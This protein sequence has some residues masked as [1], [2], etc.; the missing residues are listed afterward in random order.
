M[1]LKS[2]R[3]N[4]FKSFA[5]EVELLFEEGITVIVG[6]N[7]CGKSNISDAIRWVLGEQSARSLR[8]ARMEEVIF[9]GGST[10]SP[11]KLAY[12]AL[13]LSNEDGFLPIDSPE[14]E[15]ARQ[16][17]R[18]GESRYFINGSQCLLRD[19]QNLFLDTGIGTNAYYLMEQN[20]IDFILNSKPLERRYLFDE[21]AGIN[22]YKRR[23]AEALRK[24][25]ETE[26]NLARINDV[27][28][29]LERE[30]ESLREQAERARIYL[31]LMERLKKADI[32]RSRRKYRLLTEELEGIEEKLEEVRAKLSEREEELARLEAELGESSSR[33]EEIDAEIEEIQGRIR[34]VESELDRTRSNIEIYADRRKTLLASAA[35]MRKEIEAASKRR[36]ELEEEIRRRIDERR[37]VEVN[38]ELERNRLR[39]H[40]SFIAEMEKRIRD[41]KEEIEVIR[42]RTIQV[43]EERSRVQNELSSL[44]SKAELSRKRLARLSEEKGTLEGELD[45]LRSSLEESRRR[46]KLVEAEIVGLNAELRSVESELKSLQEELRR[47]EAE[48]SGTQNSLGLALS[49]L[50]SLKER[51]SSYE[52][53]IT[54]VRAV[55]KAKELKPEEFKGICG[56]VGELI[57]TEP[58]YELAI[59]VALG[60]G[61]HNVVTE[62]AEDAQKAIEL[63]KSARAGRVTF[64][65][66]DLLRARRFEGSREMLLQPGVIGIASELVRFDPKYSVVIEYL[67]GN[68]LVVESLEVAVNLLRRFGSPVRFVTLEGEMVSPSGAITGGYGKVKSS[69]LLSRAREI[70]ELEERA[71][72]LSMKLREKDEER[73]AVSA[74]ISALQKRRGELLLSSQEGRV[75]L[76]ELSKEIQSLEE[77]ERRLLGQMEVL[78]SEGEVIEREL[79]EMEGEAEKL[80]ARL[81]EL[82]G[83]ETTLGR[84]LRRLMEQVEIEEGK[85]N[86]VEKRCSEERVKLAKMEEQLRGIQ[87]AIDAMEEERRRIGE[88]IEEMR[89]QAESQEE[90]KAELSRRIEEEKG[91][92]MELEKHLAELR[93]KLASLQGERE[94]VGRRI[95]EAEGQIGSIRRSISSLEAR[96]HQLEIS[97]REIQVQI[98]SVRRYV[99]ERYGEEIESA[100][101]AFQER[102]DE[103]L[104]S[105]ISSAKAEIESM[106]AVNLRAIDDYNSYKER[107]DFMIAQR[108]DLLE[109]RRSIYKAIDRINAAS[110]QV[111]LESFEKVNGNFREVFRE[112]F[113]GGEA[114]LRLI[115]DDPLECGVEI[116]ACPPGKRPQSISQLSGGERALV[117]IALLFAI[118]KLK[119]APFCILDEV[120]AAL[121]EAN[122]LRFT[123]LIKRFSKEIQFI[124]ITH[125]KRTMEIADLMYGVTM[126]KAGVSKVISVKFAP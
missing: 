114:E 30:T 19:I 81:E 26:A 72:K 65:P 25:E 77:R 56:V 110:R 21:V 14:V 17:T 86:E 119:P 53:Y 99:Y 101:P 40:E 44:N 98:D 89:R 95:S 4:G 76:A 51:Q 7:G 60:S 13:K 102:S 24:L 29:E 87:E 84:K 122:V 47:I 91:K 79:E 88:K 71:E 49:R 67:L 45:Q 5:D 64:L 43:M 96:R 104:E 20:N 12:V 70:E 58:E 3:I 2:L 85:R 93:E 33:R 69:G 27:I 92:F 32:E 48:I 28:A 34:K 73:K 18:S 54:G 59:E 125:N 15:I 111:F 82:K 66:L 124:I 100:E 6:P 31:D 118:F 112:L 126:E 9:N 50:E 109:A 80:K 10:G 62:T 38:I 42:R 1:R 16:L 55:M 39:A 106:G 22:R 68:T 121:D 103:E 74:R 23:K 35:Q 78:R 8:C 46:R 115:G 83:E 123:R 116:I 36:R 107:L 97:L 94:E 41:A 61:I 37:R 105:I 117:A 108:D 57:R 90:L 52:G 75:K 11:K 63:L 120:D 113:D